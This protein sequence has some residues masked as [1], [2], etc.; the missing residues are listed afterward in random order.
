MDEIS[1]TGLN[2]E[3]RR[4]EPMSRH[5]SWR[6]GGSARW[7]YTPSGVADLGEFLKRVPDETDIAWCGLGSNLLVRDGGFNGVL[8]STHKGL[9]SLCRTGERGIYAEAGVPGAKL[10]KFAARN[11][12]CGTEF[13]VGIPGTV[14]GALAMNAG[15]FG[16]ETWENV[17]YADTISRRGERGR[18]KAAEVSWGYRSVELDAAEW[19][20]GA[21]FELAPCQS[22]EGKQRIRSYLKRR[23]ATQ[24]VQTANAGSVFRN[25]GGDHAARLLD[26]AGLKG[27]AIGAARVSPIHANFIENTGRASAADIESLIDCMLERVAAVHDMQL[28]LEVRIIGKRR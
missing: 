3:L 2:G 26:S 8:I 1:M 24:P 28:E 13:M 4:N 18:R 16:S 9:A 14:G 22:D 20:T 21:E 25:P 6:A 7:F 17:R 11:A 27:H 5:T 23:A 19:F 10:A 12:L 15:C